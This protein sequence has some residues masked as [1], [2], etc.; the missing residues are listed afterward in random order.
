LFDLFVKYNYGKQLASALH[1]GK[2]IGQLQCYTIPQTY[3]RLGDR[4]FLMVEPKV[5]N[6][7]LA[8][9]RKPDIEFVQMKRLF[10]AFLCGEAH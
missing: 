5:W 9:L 8:T 4:S 3:T 7:F 6:N 10:K 2:G 1:V